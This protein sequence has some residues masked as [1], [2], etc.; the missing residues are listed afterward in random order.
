MPISPVA[1]LTMVSMG[2]L[3]PP[4]CSR[5][6]FYIGRGGRGGGGGGEQGVRFICPYPCAVSLLCAVLLANGVQ[7][8]D[9]GRR[10]TVPLIIRLPRRVIA[11]HVLASRYKAIRARR[12][13]VMP[14]L[15]H[16]DREHVAP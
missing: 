13:R 10:R 4:Q 14:L 3:P 12:L 9:N 8:T 7:L 5:Q 15:S 16:L 1:A 2:V 6:D 11:D